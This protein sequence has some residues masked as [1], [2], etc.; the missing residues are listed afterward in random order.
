MG[1][2]DEYII[3]IDGG[4]IMRKPRVI[5]F[6]DEPTLLELLELCFARWGYEV[7]SYRTPVVCPLNGN[8]PQRNFR[9]QL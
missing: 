2:L 8:A 3:T 6:D 9:R 4:P 1:D 7:F 5:I